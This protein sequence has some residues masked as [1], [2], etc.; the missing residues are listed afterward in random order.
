M[1]SN[2]T[3]SMHATPTPSATLYRVTPIDPDGHVFQVTVT[4]DAPDPQGQLFSLPTWIPGSYLIREFAKNIVTMRAY[5]GPP[6][7]LT[8]AIDAA[9]PAPQAPSADDEDLPITK[10]DKA[11]WRVATGD[12]VATLTVQMQVYAWDL[13]VRTA[14]LD[15]TRGFFNGS[16]LFL[17][18]HGREQA[19]CMLTLERPAGALY[20]NWRVATTL[21]RYKT[22]PGAFGTYMAANYDALIDHPIELGEFLTVEFDACGTPHDIVLAGRFDADTDRLRADVSKI[23]DAI[24]RLFEPEAARAPFDRY[25][26]QCAVVGDGYGG[27]EHRDST[28]LLFSRNDLPFKGM[29]APTDGYRGLLGLFSHEYFHAWHVKRIKPAAFSPYDLSRESYT[30]LLWLFEGFTSYYDDLMLLRSGVIER[31][32][33]LKALAKTMSQVMRGTG[34]LKQ[35]VADSSFD[36]W[37]KYY[38]QDEN[39]PNAIV[40]YYTKGALVGLCLDLSI[41]AASQGKKSLDDVMRALWQTYGA[42]FERHQRGLPD[43]QAF[44]ALAERATGVKLRKLTEL[45]VFGTSDLPLQTLLA[46]FGVSIDWEASSKGPSLGVKSL[47][48]ADGVLLQQV[49]SGA[50]AHRGGLSAGDLLIAAD[51]IRLH[52]NG[53]DTVLQRRQPGDWLSLHAFRRDELMEFRVQLDEPSREQCK[54]RVEGKGNKLGAGWLRSV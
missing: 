9:T 31:D 45:A 4:I 1:A 49:L 50:A 32:D 47:G 13:S 19:A 33:Y 38:R 22:R 23:C 41:R 18:P 46:R 27:L 21:P 51:G 2:T 54:L 5:A 42:D 20:R 25:Q 34:R 36:A 10:V 29:Q 40:S 48:R 26:F 24:I 3:S 44:I 7:A 12:G 6:R 37:T 30:S 14:Y 17:Q 43:E 15:R 35:S 16:S 52:N 39:A 28:A 11:S 8:D 53:L